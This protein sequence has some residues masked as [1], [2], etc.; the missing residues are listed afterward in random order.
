M[1]RKEEV[2]WEAAL[3]SDVGASMRMAEGGA[4]KFLASPKQI[5]IGFGVKEERL[6]DLWDREDWDEEREEKAKAAGRAEAAMA[7]VVVATVLRNAIFFN[8]Q[9]FVLV[10]SHGLLF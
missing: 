3:L 2:T 6:L 10:D 7:V 5:G 8:S 1:G 4:A 9:R